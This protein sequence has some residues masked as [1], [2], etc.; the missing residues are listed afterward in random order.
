L[1]VTWLMREHRGYER[2]LVLEDVVEDRR[3]VALLLEGDGRLGCSLD[4]RVSL[5]P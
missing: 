5:A 2:C 3:S 1:K 4:H